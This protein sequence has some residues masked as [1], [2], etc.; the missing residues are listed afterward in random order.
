MKLGT[1]YKQP[2]ERESYTIDYAQDL[3][4]GDNLLS[5]Q[6]TV[7]PAGL[8]VQPLFVTDPKL[9]FWVSGG[10]DGVS[11]KITITA[12][13]ADNRILQDEVIVKIKEI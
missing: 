2:A 6:A 4:A 7:E 11:Y 13:T 9:R 3:T 8:D 5:A 1:Y 10:T 12:T